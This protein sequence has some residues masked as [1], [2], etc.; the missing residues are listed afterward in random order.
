ME[1]NKNRA[2]HGMRI[3]AAA[4]L[5]VPALALAAGDVTGTPAG[6]PPSTTSTVDAEFVAKAAQGGLAEVALG[7]LAEQ[8]SENEAVDAF[9]ARMQKDHS[10]ANAELETIATRHGL[11]VPKALDPAHQQMQTKLQALEGDAFDEAYGKAMLEDHA[12]TIALFQKQSEQGQIADLRAFAQKTLPTLEA[13]HA[14]A[15]DLPGTD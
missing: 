10:A 2:G 5:A 4:L 6:A 3:A 12:K 14:L 8:R 11:A 7:K 15:K 13:H 1:A 9:A